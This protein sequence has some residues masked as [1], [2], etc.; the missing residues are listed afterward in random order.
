[1]YEELTFAT[2]LTSAF[3]FLSSPCQFLTTLLFPRCA[4]CLKFIIIFHIT[5]YN[6]KKIITNRIIL[7]TYFDSHLHYRIER[8]HVRCETLACVRVMCQRRNVKRDAAR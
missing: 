8:I 1:M 5:I 4:N 6:S 2:N 3:P 7:H